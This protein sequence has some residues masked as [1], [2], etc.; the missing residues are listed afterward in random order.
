[1]ALP[2]V[3]HTPVSSKGPN[4]FFRFVKRS[5]FE[6]SHT[7]HLRV[8]NLSICIHVNTVKT[9][10]LDCSQAKEAADLSLS[11]PVS[12]DWRTVE[13]GRGCSVSCHILAGTSSPV[14]TP[15]T[16]QG[17]TVLLATP[18]GRD[19]NAGPQWSESK[20]LISERS[21]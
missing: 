11:T 15:N 3:C 7:P 4:N 1:M 9:L 5:R 19:L 13:E 21:E 16:K 14:T 6:I 18:A 17:R 20:N 10:R 2:S 8:S 12:C